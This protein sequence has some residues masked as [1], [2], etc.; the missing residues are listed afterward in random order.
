[1]WR[2]LHRTFDHQS[3][4]GY[5]ERQAGCQLKRCHELPR[6]LRGVLHR[7]F[8]YQSDSWNA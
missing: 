2:L 6:Q 1:M 8:D 4:S 5:A 3:D 7:P